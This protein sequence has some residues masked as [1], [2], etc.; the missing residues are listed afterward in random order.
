MKKKIA[1][2]L[3]ALVL[4]LSLAPAA[5]ASEVQ[6][7]CNNEIVGTI[8]VADEYGNDVQYNIYDDSVTDIPIYAAK[9]GESNTRA[10]TN[11]ATLTIGVGNGQAVFQFTPTNVGIALLTV[12]F[13]GDFT[14][15]HS[16][17]KYGYNNYIIPV[18]SGSVSAS[19]SGTGSISGSYSVLGYETASVIKGFS[20]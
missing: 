16:G 10:L 15:Y 1:S 2:I 18:L 11:V 17:I 3:M 13:T 7:Q 19:T 6:A 8:V 14:T 9:T 4:C 5:F 12:G 20:W